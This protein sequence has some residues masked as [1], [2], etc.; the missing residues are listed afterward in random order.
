MDDV[1]DYRDNI[2]KE[3]RT[4]KT[5]INFY[6]PEKYAGYAIEPRYPKSISPPNIKVRIISNYLTKISG[7]FLEIC[8]FIGSFYLLFFQ[9]KKQE[10][11]EEYIIMSLGS[12]FILGIVILVPYVSIAYNAERVYQQSLVLL[13]LPAILGILVVFKFLKNKKIIFLLLTIIL[14]WCFLTPSGFTSQ[15]VGG[16]PQMNLN[17]FGEGYDRFY[18]HESEVKSLEWLSKYY[19]QKDMIYLDRYA[20][21]KAY[22][23]SR[24]NKKNII[25]DI[26]PSTIN[27]NSYVYSSYVNTIDKRTFIFYKLK[28]MSYNFPTEFLNNN[29]S[30]IYNNGSSEIF[31]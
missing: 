30:K 6:S 2:T 29:K 24:I 7:I 22:Y 14:I 21:L 12:T 17:N 11:H 10:I 23:F 15:I 26:L 25:N 28:V 9:L 1:K 31:K 18:T 13:S 20:T 4:N 16:T 3:Y 5:W 19:N 8:I 27:K